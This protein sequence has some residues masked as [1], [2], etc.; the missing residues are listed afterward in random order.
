MLFHVKIVRCFWQYCVKT[1]VVLV[2]PCFL[3]PHTRAILIKMCVLVWLK[4][5]AQAGIFYASRET[6]Q[7]LVLNIFVDFESQ[8]WHLKG[9]EK[10][11]AIIISRSASTIVEKG[12]F[13]HVKG[14]KFAW[15]QKAFFKFTVKLNTCYWENSQHKRRANYS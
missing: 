4:L 13:H 1:I 14:I 11:A 9:M 6:S 8:F 15:L 12:I 3:D 5:T 10:H 7:N 2:Y